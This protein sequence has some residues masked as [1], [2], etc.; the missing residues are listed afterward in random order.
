MRI[1]KCAPKHKHFS[2]SQSLFY[3]FSTTIAIHNLD[4]Y[5][6]MSDVL[7]LLN[8]TPSEVLLSY[9]TLN[10]KWKELK[11]V[12]DQDPKNK[13]KRAHKAKATSKHEILLERTVDI[14]LGTYKSGVLCETDGKRKKNARCPCRK[15]RPHSSSRYAECD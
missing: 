12:R 8:V 4:L 11:K 5:L 6:F 1:A 3:R 15:G 13:R 7:L 10:D 9:T 14:K 2:R